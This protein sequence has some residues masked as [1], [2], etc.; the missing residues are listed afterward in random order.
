MVQHSI[1]LKEYD[2]EYFDLIQRI[3]LA[4]KLAPYNNDFKLKTLLYAAWDTV[5]LLL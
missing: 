4:P 1:V 5:N 3:I 2:I